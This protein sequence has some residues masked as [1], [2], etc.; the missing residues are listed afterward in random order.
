MQQI[1]YPTLHGGQALSP[2]ASVLL[3]MED[4][5]QRIDNAFSYFISSTDYQGQKKKKCSQCPS[6]RLNYIYKVLSVTS[7]C[8]STSSLWPMTVPG[9]KLDVL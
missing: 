1:T 3:L 9:E 7:P 5:R 2:Q 6:K 8:I 4:K